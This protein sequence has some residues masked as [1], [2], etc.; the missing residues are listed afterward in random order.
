MYK[1]S[2]L[3]TTPLRFLK[4]C[5]LL[6]INLYLPRWVYG[7]VV[8]CPGAAEGSV[9]SGSGLKNLRRRGHG[10]KSHPTDW[11]SR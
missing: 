4:M 8:L 5:Q 9:G 2:G 7:F 3:S 6:G 10:L 11:E 1:V